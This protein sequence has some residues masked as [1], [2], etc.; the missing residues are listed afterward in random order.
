MSSP[1]N[2]FLELAQ[3]RVDRDDRVP[4]PGDDRVVESG[5]E[6]LNLPRP[7]PHGCPMTC[8]LVRSRI[9]LTRGFPDL[10]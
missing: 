3:S 8:D 10:P 5:L 9:V 1:A 7:P 4:P 6:F 2:S